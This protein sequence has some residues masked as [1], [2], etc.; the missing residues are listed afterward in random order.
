MV[1]TGCTSLSTAVAGGPIY[2]LVVHVT[3]DFTYDNASGLFC[4]TT[5]LNIDVSVIIL[6]DLILELLHCAPPPNLI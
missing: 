5:K 6:W 2:C 4:S 3:P 1:V